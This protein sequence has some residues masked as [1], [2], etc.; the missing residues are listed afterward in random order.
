[1]NDHL[2]DRCAEEQCW[3]RNAAK[4]GEV[5]IATCRAFRA[6]EKRKEYRPEGGPFWT[7]HSGG[8]RE[9]WELWF[10][11]TFITTF[12]DEGVARNY[13]DL[14][15]S[16]CRQWVEKK[17][18]K[19]ALLNDLLS[20]RMSLLELGKALQRMEQVPDPWIPVSDRLP[21]AGRMVL[22]YCEPLQNVPGVRPPCMDR[23]VYDGTRWVCLWDFRVTH[24][25][26]L[27]DPP[28]GKEKE[29]RRDT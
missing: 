24:W 10:A 21:E 25:R 22:G 7:I 27:P 14:L 29:A 17:E 13:V 5:T 9:V 16:A 4:V 11:D 23:V 12:S 1:M 28:E 3:V 26:P 15:N 20:A 18:E 6:Q 8:T 2:C 19:I